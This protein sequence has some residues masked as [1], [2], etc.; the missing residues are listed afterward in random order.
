VESLKVCK[1]FSFV[2]Y[3]KQKVFVVR[4]KIKEGELE[5]QNVRTLKVIYYN[6]DKCRQTLAKIVI[7]DKL[8]SNFVEGQGFR[9]FTRTMQPR[10]DIPSHFIVMR[11]CLK[12]YIEE[13]ERLRTALKDQRLCF[14]TNTRISIQNINY[15]YLTAF[16]IDNE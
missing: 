3:K 9:L 5:D 7:I 13:K 14:I 15:I 12:L 8:P 2:V 16:W 4:P 11:N 6:Y 10:F 1:K